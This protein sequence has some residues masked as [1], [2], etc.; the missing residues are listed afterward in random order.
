MI[1]INLKNKNILVTFLE[2]N[3]FSSIFIPV[4]GLSLSRPEINIV[5]P[6]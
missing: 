3:G 6:K 1:E 5:V 4:T 2:S